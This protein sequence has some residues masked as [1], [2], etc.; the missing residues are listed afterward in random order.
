MRAA[1]LVL[2]L[3]LSIAIANAIPIS[4]V[5]TSDDNEP[6][7]PSLTSSFEEGRGRRG[8]GAAAAAAATRD[9]DLENSEAFTA[10]AAAAVAVA[11]PSSFLVELD[12]AP[13]GVD[14]QERI[15]MES[16]GEFKAFAESRRVTVS[17]Q[18]Q[19]FQ[20]LLRE[21]L[22]VNYAVRHEFFDL[23]NGLSIEL[24][25]VSQDK[26]SQILERIRATPGVVKV[27]PLISLSQPKTIVHGIG[28]DALA[29]LPQLSTAHEQTGVLSARNDLHLTGK[30]IKIGIIDTGVDYTHEALGSCYGQGCKVAY[31]YDFVEPFRTKQGG[32]YDCVGHGTHVA[33]IIAGNSSKSNFYGVAPEATLGSYRV[34]PCDG[35]SKDDVIIAALERAYNDGMDVVNLSLGGGSAWPN[36]PLSNVAGNLAKLGVVVV[37]AIGN[38]GDEGIDEVSSPS[39]NPAVVSVASFEGSGYLA[40][41]F[42]VQGAPD[43]RID[44]SDTPPENATG[45]ALTLV[46]PSHDPE[47]CQDYPESVT[48]KVVL[49]KRGDCA[50]TSK[51]KLAQDAG[52][53]GCIFYNNV[54]GALR[55]KTTGPDIHIF[56]HGISM[57]QGEALLK[58]FKATKNNTLSIVYKDQK[59]V[60][61]NEMA[62]QISTFSSWGL[63]P[64]LEMKPDIGAPGG[65]IYSTVPVEKGS[66][67][68]MSGT[69][70]ATPYV[71]GCAALLL[72]SDPSAN[73]NDV[74]GRLRLY[75]KPGLYK[76]T[77]IPDSVARQGAGMVHVLNAIQGKLLAQP[78]HL[79]LNDTD[80]T[81]STYTITLTNLYPK[82]E[83]F[84]ISHIPAM[85]VLGFTPTGQ[86][87][88]TVIYSDS[89]A[90]LVLDPTESPPSS[91][92]RLEAGET[93]S[94]K[95]SFSPSKNL[96]L[97]SHWIY[98]GYVKIQPTI[99]KTRPAL[100][101]PYAGM[102]GS[103]K[104]VD[105]LDLQDGFPVL[106]G[107]APDG[108]LVPIE[109]KNGDP[110]PMYTM[111]GQDIVTLL[112]KVSNP[113]RNI[114]VYILDR[115]MKKVIGIVPVDGEYVGRTDAVKSK[116]FVVTWAGRK[117]DPQS[118]TVLDVPDGEYSLVVVAPKPFSTTF[119]IQAGPHESWMS[120]A[121]MIQRRA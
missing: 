2:I 73:R 61:K 89:A 71:A 27:S 35:N 5:F 9:I 75:S 47:G 111:T 121:I 68:T 56:G 83:V 36:T 25:D 90:E 66:Y 70:M 87:A 80:N 94:F 62:N 100:Q 32:G 24:Q 82:A 45:T 120:P 108:K 15:R 76:D 110:P 53:I 113:A 112:L 116:F 17:A 67:A 101:V 60:F 114:Q 51:V 64:E 58:Q 86:P 12:L 10:A 63:G 97:Q 72:E 19:S 105:I 79:P 93:R 77:V 88:G 46:L 4:P 30:G 20:S 23:M 57:K 38:D 41:Y 103:Y 104:T 49:V 26:L 78:T 28:F 6:F 106:L 29:V 74:L 1:S 13:T 11:L 95:I 39:I 102:R 69:S 52:A 84:S 117:F 33:G 55:P 22:N 99:D 3:S 44:Y 115:N 34:F 109:T 107:R 40:N 43:L 96:D 37:A 91:T 59:G 21:S 54:E 7:V 119:D 65:Y 31:G 14:R 42:E 85:S 81:L 8:G 98:S 16:S 118:G 92:I 18:H 50:F 48:G